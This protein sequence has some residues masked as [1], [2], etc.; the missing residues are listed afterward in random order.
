[1]TICSPRSQKKNPHQV[2]SQKCLANANKLTFCMALNQYLSRGMITNIAMSMR[3]VCST[4]LSQSESHNFGLFLFFA[5]D[6]FSH[7]PTLN[8]DETLQVLESCDCLCLSHWP[9]FSHIHLIGL[10]GADHD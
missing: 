2:R 10:P 6:L 5:Q 3:L 9:F 7:T 8:F 1:M 4:Y